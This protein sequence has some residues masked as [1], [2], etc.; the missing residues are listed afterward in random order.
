M[1]NGIGFQKQVHRFNIVY[2]TQVVIIDC[3]LIFDY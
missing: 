1:N 3:H 2:I